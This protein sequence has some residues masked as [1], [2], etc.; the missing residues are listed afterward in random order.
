MNASSPTR[1]DVQIED[2]PAL[3]LE[4]PK[5]TARPVGT[6]DGCLLDVV[7][8]N[9]LPSVGVFKPFSVILPTTFF[10]DL[11][12]DEVR[13]VLTGPEAERMSFTTMEDT[14]LDPGS[15]DVTLRCTVSRIY[16][17]FSDRLTVPVIVIW[18]ILARS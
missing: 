16:P 6:E 8:Y 5:R 2:H 17:T 10:Q 13:V 3:T 18:P 7:I 11:S 15:T 14:I 9:S 12:V 4:I 1:P